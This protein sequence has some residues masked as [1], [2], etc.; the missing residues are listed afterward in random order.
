MKHYEHQ[1]E[2]QRCSKRKNNFW[3]RY[4]W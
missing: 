2:F 4:N 1:Y 3:I